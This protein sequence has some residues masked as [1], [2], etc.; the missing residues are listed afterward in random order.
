MRILLVEDDERIADALAEDL[1]DHNHVV[2]VAQDGQAGWEFAEAYDFDLMLLDVMLPRLSGIQLCQKLRASGY[3]TPILMLTARDTIEDR[4]MGLDAGADDYLVKPFHLK[5]L[6]ARI[7][8]LMRRGESTLPPV[9]AWGDL[10]LNPSTC[11]VTYGAEEL[12]LS[13]KEYG[14]LE[15]FL[16]HQRRVFSRG[17]LLEQLWGFEDMPEEATVKAHIRGLRKKLKQA[18]VPDLIET[19]YG[20]GYRLRDAEA[21]LVS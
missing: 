15:F 10:Q 16:R 1:S 14:L 6:S 11:E 4:V 8:A 13:P 3:A 17:Q 18:G 20:L 19:V 12:A 7:R 2:E 5:E 9:L 21:V